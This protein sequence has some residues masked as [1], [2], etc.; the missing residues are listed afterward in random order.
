MLMLGFESMFQ[1]CVTCN[2]ATRRVLGLIVVH[3]VVVLRGHITIFLHAP[4]GRLL[5]VTMIGHANFMHI[6][7]LGA[8]CCN[9]PFCIG[10]V[11][12]P[13][14]VYGILDFYVCAFI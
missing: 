12:V 7:S 5:M 8:P 11:L 4:C 14:D 9:F 6:R 3:G 1:C 13:F 10:D 2:G